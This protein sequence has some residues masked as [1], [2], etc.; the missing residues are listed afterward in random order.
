MAQIQHFLKRIN[1]LSEKH[2]GGKI[3]QEKV[4]R[5]PTLAEAEKNTKMPW[6]VSKK[7]RVM[8][9]APPELPIALGEGTLRTWGIRDVSSPWAR[10]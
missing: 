7:F 5:P 6:G 2:G 9:S 1:R 4:W 8:R 10:F 3:R